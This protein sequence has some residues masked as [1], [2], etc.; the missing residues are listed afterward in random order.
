MNKINVNQRTIGV[1]FNVSG[2]A[3]ILVWAPLADSVFISIRDQA[4]LP[5]A[6]QELGYWKLDT[7]RLKPGMTYRFIINNEPVPDVASLFQPDSVHGPSQAFN[8]ND[9]NWTDGSWQN[10]ALQDYLMYELHTGTFTPESTFEGIEQKLDYLIDLGIT[11]IEL[12]PVAQF[13][14]DR[15]WGYDGVYPFAVQNSYGGPFGLQQLVNACHRKGLAVVLDVVYNHVGPEGNYL[16]KYGPYFTDKY[17]TPWGNAVNFDDAG[18]NQVRRYFI[19]NALMW[20]RDFHVDALRMDAVHAIKD[21]S[22]KHILREIKEHVDELMQQTGKIHYL[23]VECDLND[24]RFIN[25]LDQQ[26]YGMDTQWIDEFHHALRVT[27]GGKK[28]G[29]YS[30]FNPVSSLAEA[31]VNGY[32]Y[33]GQYSVHR[34][35]YFGTTTENNP[36]RQ[37]VVFSQNHD[38]VGNRML[39]ERSSQLFSFE[40]QKLLAGAVMVSPFLPML[41]MGEEYSEPHPFLYF[42]SHTDPELVIAV[43]KGRKAEFAAFHSEGE[44][45]NPD[46]MKTFQQSKLQWDILDEEPQKTMLQY[47]KALIA[48]RKKYPALKIPDRKKLKIAYDE[49]AKTITLHRWQDTQSIVCFMNFSAEQQPIIIPNDI[50]QWQKLFDSADR[51]WK[52]TASSPELIST[53]MSLTVQPESIIIYTQYYV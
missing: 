17:K 21:L 4:L 23:I 31:Y 44:A 2:T 33:H 16:N 49:S 11:A 10:I 53:G 40:M 48:L 19:E 26:G 38:Q 41:F 28:E 37:F 1:T 3:E 7:D 52:G 22:P 36:G 12:M 34:E 47:Y 8:V 24:T 45:P 43:R 46:A 20:F 35:K 9:F 13:P 14:G 5:L 32:V 6:K 25:P 50:Q 51:K 39:G 29:Y 30:D 42:I 27:A 18:C 15:N